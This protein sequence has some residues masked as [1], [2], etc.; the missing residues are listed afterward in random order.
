M[1]RIFPY[2]VLTASLVLM[3]LLLNG[4]SLGHFVLGLCIA[5]GASLAMTALHPAKARLRNWRAVFALIGMVLK[6][7]LVS[8]ITVAKVVLAGRRRSPNAGFVIIPLEVRHPLALAALACIITSAPG[9]AWLEYR[10][11]SGKLMIHVL[12]LVD[13]QDWIN[14]VKQ[15]YE[16]LLMEIF[17]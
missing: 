16:P 12:D 5:T 6:D 15:R 3:W 1:R 4:F 7:I 9:T 17:E 10:S 2:P 14:L 8:N 13:E 11:S